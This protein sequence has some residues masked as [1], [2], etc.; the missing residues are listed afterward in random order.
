MMEDVTYHELDKRLSLLES[1]I[2][3]FLGT[4]DKDA[5]EHRVYVHDNF[6]ELKGSMIV[7]LDKLNNLP[8]ETR[9]ELGKVRECYIDQQFKSLW[10]VITVIIIGVLGTAWRLLF[11]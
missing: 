3:S 11:Q 1:E 10:G 8:C 7:I 5:K 6:H 2:K 4:H 9:K